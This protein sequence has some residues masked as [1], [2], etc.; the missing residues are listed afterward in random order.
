MKKIVLG[1][2]HTLFLSEN[3]NLIASGR[4][5]AIKICDN[6]IKLMSSVKEIGCGLNYSVAI[7]EKNVLH[8]WGNLFGKVLL[9]PCLIAGDVQA[10]SCS[11]NY[12]LFVSKGCLYGAGKCQELGIDYQVKLVKHGNFVDLACSRTHYLV[13]DII[14]RVFVYDFKLD[15]YERFMFGNNNFKQILKLSAG[16]NRCAVRTD[17]ITFFWGYDEYRRG[18]F[19]YPYLDYETIEVLSYNKYS[20]FVKSDSVHINGDFQQIV[21]KCSRRLSPES[22]S[23]ADIACNKDMILIITKCSKLC[24]YGN[25]DGA[26]LGLSELGFTTKDNIVDLKIIFNNWRGIVEIIPEISTITKVDLITE[27]PEPSNKLEITCNISF[28]STNMDS[29]TINLIG[30]NIPKVV[31]INF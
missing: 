19:E 18:T 20:L 10:I 26:M 8:C 25:F 16:T 15:K 17:K 7:D 28:G 23:V 12:C 22:L 6:Y 30:Q 24:S 29:V 5:E 14:D 4:Y 21:E 3:N 2:N 1:D 27:F 13:K 11:D 9:E 31:K